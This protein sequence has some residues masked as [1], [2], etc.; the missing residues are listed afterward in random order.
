MTAQAGRAVETEPAV[1][2]AVYAESLVEACRVAR[3]VGDVA[4]HQRYSE[5]LERCLQFLTTLQYT[6][7]GVQH[8]ERWYRPRIVGAF[9]ASHRDG[10][11]RIDYTQHAVSALVGYLE[12]TPAK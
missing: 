1:D 5:A 12:H 10:N 9:H 6:D 11:L 7:A 4:R 8:F 3:E 2:S